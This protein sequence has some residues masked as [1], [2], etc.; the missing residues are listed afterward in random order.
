M[1]F[2]VLTLR[3]I[4]QNLLAYIATASVQEAAYEHFGESGLKLI[5]T[6]SQTVGNRAVPV[7]PA[8][9]FVEDDAA[10]DY[11]GDI[12][13]AV[14][15]ATFEVRIQNSDPDEAMR[16]AAIYDGAVEWMIANCPTIKDG[17]GAISINLDEP[18]V[19]AFEDLKSNDNQND[20]LQVFK[21]KFTWVIK[22]GAYE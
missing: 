6:V 8:I 2:N 20:F 1:T 16:Q 13:Q 3:A 17:T 19:D 12:L 7:Y 21:K 4:P 9:S 15:S 14:Y 22:A 18:V 10:K 5:K 11:Q